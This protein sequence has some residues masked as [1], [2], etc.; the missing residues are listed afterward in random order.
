MMKRAG[1]TTK[2]MSY[3][4]GQLTLTTESSLWLFATLLAV[5]LNTMFKTLTHNLINMKIELPKGKDSALEL[6]ANSCYITIGDFTYYFDD[7]I[8]GERIVQRWRRDVFIRPRDI[9][10]IQIEETELCQ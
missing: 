9:E 7:S 4:N 8:K 5:L 2:A 10:D 1:M 6:D 3:V